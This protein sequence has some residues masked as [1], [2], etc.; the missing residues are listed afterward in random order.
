MSIAIE[1]G[2][3]IEI[4][5]DS[6]ESLVVQTGQL[7]LFDTFS[8]DEKQTVAERFN[9]LVR[10]TNTTEPGGK[11]GLLRATI[12]QFEA[13]KNSGLHYEVGDRNFKDASKKKAAGA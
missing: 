11:A 4:K 6:F 2:K 8:P 1:S 13:E 12:L 5:N 7:I 10:I 9:N 3:G